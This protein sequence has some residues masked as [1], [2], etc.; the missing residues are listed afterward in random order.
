VERVNGHESLTTTHLYWFCILFTQINALF[1][2]LAFLMENL[3]DMDMI[4][5]STEY[6]F[7]CKQ[8]QVNDHLKKPSEW[9]LYS[10]ECIAWWDDK[11]K[12]LIK[13]DNYD[14]NCPLV[15][16]NEIMRVWVTKHKRSL[17]EKAGQNPH[18]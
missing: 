1:L 7:R 3:K 6:Y 4:W 12:E 11:K 14:K 9:V 18:D 5:I 13:S 2:T 10:S 15:V 17:L 16:Y 8:L